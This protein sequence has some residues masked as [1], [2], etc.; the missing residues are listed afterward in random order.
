MHF[1][2]DAARSDANVAMSA[3]G[4]AGCR[5]E[6]Y[7]CGGF[8]RSDKPESDYSYD[9]LA[10]DLHRVLDQRGLQNVTLVGLPQ[11]NRR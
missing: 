5:V 4:A 1:A 2:C 8:G 9:T 3:P 10:D 11:L 6:A 7:D